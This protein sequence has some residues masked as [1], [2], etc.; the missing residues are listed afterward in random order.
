MQAIASRDTLPERLIRSALHGRGYRYRVNY[1]PEPEVRTTLD[2]A[3][4]RLKV[5]VYVDGCFW[6]SCPEH[7][8]LPKTRT[9]WW[10]KKLRATVVRDRRNT[11][12]L[13]NRGWTIVRIWEHETLDRAVARIELALRDLGDQTD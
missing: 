4:T 2:I 13:E 1:R 8:H 3:F 6:H 5:G 10:R 11:R 12:A 7:G 9:I